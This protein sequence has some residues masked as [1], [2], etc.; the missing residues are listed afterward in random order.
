ML[1]GVPLCTR[2]LSISVL[3][4]AL[5][6]GHV[7]PPVLANEELVHNMCFVE[8]CQINTTNLEFAR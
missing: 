6:H 4:P 3:T 7:L 5:S 2:R 8:E 1:G